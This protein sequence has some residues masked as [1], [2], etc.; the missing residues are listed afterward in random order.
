MARAKKLAQDRL[1]IFVLYVVDGRVERACFR[2]KAERLK[3]KMGDK[4]KRAIVDKFFQRF[5]LGVTDAAP[6]SPRAAR[7]SASRSR[8]SQYREGTVILEI[9]K[10]DAA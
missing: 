8:R 9:T 5:E 1:P 4:A 10:R 6:T 2:A 7:R 3:S